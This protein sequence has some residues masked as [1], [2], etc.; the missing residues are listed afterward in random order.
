MT[1][2]IMGL[3]AFVRVSSL[4]HSFRSLFF[5]AN[6]LKAYTISVSLHTLVLHPVKCEGLQYKSV[7][8]EWTLRPWFVWCW[9][10]WL[11]TV[12]TVVCWILEY[13]TR[14]TFLNTYIVC[15]CFQRAGLKRRI[16]CVGWVLGK[17][18]VAYM[19]CID[20][21]TSACC[22]DF[23]FCGYYADNPDYETRYRLGKK[24]SFPGLPGCSSC[25]MP[26]PLSNWALYPHYCVNI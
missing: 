1:C 14:F 9:I 10:T 23:Q 13:W 20:R 12:L 22:S 15:V 3:F 26:C 6:S 11:L 25:S 17:F 4:F 5:H 24:C 2:L 19:S 8:L 21:K 16:V 7:C 18:S